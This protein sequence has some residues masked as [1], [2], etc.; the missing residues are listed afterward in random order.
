MAEGSLIK[1][2]VIRF[3]ADG[4]LD[5]MY[6]DPTIVSFYVSPDDAW[7]YAALLGK[8]GEYVIGRAKVPE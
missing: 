2:C 3:T 7:V 5:V 4:E 1:L 8:D 6:V